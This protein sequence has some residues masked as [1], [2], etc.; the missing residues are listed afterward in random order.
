MNPAWLWPRGFG[1]KER[2][3]RML[4]CLWKKGEMR[5]DAISTENMPGFKVK[6][7]RI[8]AVEQDIIS[9]A[10]LQSTDKYLPS[11]SA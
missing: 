7:T 5:Y 4:F 11:L 10:C 1:C 9:F 6:L 8:D 2:G 3:L